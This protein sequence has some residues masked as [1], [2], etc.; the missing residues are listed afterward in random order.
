[1]AVLFLEKQK[2][3]CELNGHG[4]ELVGVEVYLDGIVV[5]AHIYSNVPVA[6]ETAFS[7]LRTWN[8]FVG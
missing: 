1:M 3:L 4:F 6:S 7:F 8:E 5:V 2:E